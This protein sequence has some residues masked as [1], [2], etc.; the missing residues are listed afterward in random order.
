M[1]TEQIP[2]TDTPF[3]IAGR[4]LRSRLILG[5]GGFKRLETLAEAIRATR[6]E[7]GERR[8]TEGERVEALSAM[9]GGAA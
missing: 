4:T 7:W 6:A 1:S 9:Q 3:A 5:T 2:I 8:I